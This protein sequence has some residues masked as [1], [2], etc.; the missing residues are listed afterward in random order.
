MLNIYRS[1]RICLCILTSL[2]L[3]QTIRFLVLATDRHGS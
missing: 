3:L 2:T 1:R